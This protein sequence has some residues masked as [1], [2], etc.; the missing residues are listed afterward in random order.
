MFDLFKTH[1]EPTQQTI[2][3]TGSLTLIEE[4]GRLIEAFNKVVKEFNELEEKTE[5]DKNDVI[6]KMDR[7]L[8]EMSHT[9]EKFKNYIVQFDNMGIGMA[10]IKEQAQFIA[11]KTKRNTELINGL[12]IVSYK[13]LTSRVS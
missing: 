4:Y 6:K 8:Y 3:D 1:V 10:V 7:Y 12:T 11:E 2:Y 13:D 5:E 9:I